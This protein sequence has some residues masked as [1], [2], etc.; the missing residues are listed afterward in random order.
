MI[1]KP[2]SQQG[3]TIHQRGIA[4]LQR[5]NS[6]THQQLKPFAFVAW[7][8]TYAK[9]NNTCPA[10]A[11]NSSLSEI[12]QISWGETGLYLFIQQGEYT[13]WW[14][15]MGTKSLLRL[16]SSPSSLPSLQ[17]RSLSPPTSS[18]LQSSLSPNLPA[19]RLTEDAISLVL[20]TDV[21]DD[22]NM[23]IFWR[24]GKLTFS[25]PLSYSLR[26]HVTLLPESPCWPAG[27]QPDTD[28]QPIDGSVA[29]LL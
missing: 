28:F 26:R 29:R 13:L 7:S 4:L 18:L 1:Q 8:L 14:S 19:Y 21:A 5:Q 20:H 23:Y 16:Q 6:S 9:S 2:T 24:F 15:W 11:S 3:P 27:P 22:L 12:A 17:N 25:P 10:S